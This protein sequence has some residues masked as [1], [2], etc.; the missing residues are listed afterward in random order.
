MALVQLGY[1]TVF[2]LRRTY[3]APQIIALDFVTEL[4]VG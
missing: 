2:D 3:P 4:K 1:E